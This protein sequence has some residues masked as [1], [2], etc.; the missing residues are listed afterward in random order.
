[1]IA[2]LIFGPTVQLLCGSSL[3]K[4]LISSNVCFRPNLVSMNCFHQWKSKWC[5]LA[6]LKIHQRHDNEVQYMNKESSLC[7]FDGRVEASRQYWNN[8]AGTWN[9][10]LNEFCLFSIP[11]SVSSFSERFIRKIRTG[12]FGNYTCDVHKRVRGQ[13]WLE[14]ITV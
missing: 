2:I 12:N 4:N 10:Q 7:F 5:F 8:D 14:A 11:I 6:D 3:N 13:N 1:M 9:L